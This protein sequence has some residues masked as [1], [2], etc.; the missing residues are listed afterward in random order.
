MFGS[1]AVPADR[2]A[3]VTTSRDRSSPRRPISRSITNRS[4]LDSVCSAVVN[5]PTNGLVV[6]QGHQR[7]PLTLSALNLP[8]E[9]NLI[10]TPGPPATRRRSC[11]G[12]TIS[13]PLPRGFVYAAR[14]NR[15]ASRPPHPRPSNSPRLLSPHIR[16]IHYAG[17]SWAQTQRALLSLLGVPRRDMSEISAEPVLK[18]RP[19]AHRPGLD[20]ARA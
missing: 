13:A 8:I 14:Q 15:A 20:R 11:R 5:C 6:R 9:R 16:Q 7:E 4:V 2:A 1:A 18:R 12:A 10:A 19:G 3:R 17:L